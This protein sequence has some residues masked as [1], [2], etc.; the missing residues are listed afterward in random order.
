MFG[1]AGQSPGGCAVSLA[2]VGRAGEASCL[3]T[4]QSAAPFAGPLPARPA[5]VPAALRPALRGYRL[6]DLAG[7]HGYQNGAG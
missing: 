7:W 1:Q 4:A 3:G 5:R 6:R 2:R